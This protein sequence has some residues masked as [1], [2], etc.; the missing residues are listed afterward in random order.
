MTPKQNL[1]IPDHRF[2]YPN[3]WVVRR[4]RR[5]FNR[6]TA[7]SVLLLLPPITPNRTFTVLRNHPKKKC[8]NPL[9]NSHSQASK[10]KKKLIP[11]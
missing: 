3:C 1:L 6:Y 8:T 10:K 2:S 7:L 5:P 9:K 4:I 11:M